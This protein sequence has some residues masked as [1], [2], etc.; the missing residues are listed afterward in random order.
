MLSPC[1]ARVE[2][3]LVAA[4]ARLKPVA[5]ADAVV[6]RRVGVEAVLIGLVQR[7]E[8]GR[9]IRLLA[10]GGQDGAV[11]A[12]RDRDVSRRS[13]AGSSET[14]RR[15]SRAPST[16]RSAP[17]TAGS[18]ATSV[19]RLPR[20]ARA[21]AGDRDPRSRSG[22]AA[23]ARTFVHPRRAPLASG[24]FSSSGL[25]QDSACFQRREQNLHL[26]ALRVDRVVALILVVAER[27]EVPARDTRAGRVSPTV[28]T[29]RAAGPVLQ[30]ACPSARR[31]ARFPLRAPCIRPPMPPSSEKCP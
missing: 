22:T 9:A 30:R 3:R 1:S 10:T 25:N 28:G 23:A 21:P 15:P 2:R 11:L 26:L 16:R 19:A 4:R 18:T 24:I 14:S 27:R 31:I 5:L 7:A 17:T 20:R 6:Q 13:T 12:V 29:P 8:R